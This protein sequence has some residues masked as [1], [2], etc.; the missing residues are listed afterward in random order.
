MLRHVF[1][2][3]LTK[4][5]KL[6]STYVF[7]A[8]LFGAAFLW[9]NVAGGAF[10]GANAGFGEKVYVNSPRSL[11]LTLSFLSLMSITI[12][13]SVFARAI[14]QDFELDMHGLVCATPVSSRAY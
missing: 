4:R 8:V 1:L 12:V 9:T 10:E 14:A 11:L 13:S 2:F 6:V 3:E 7:F 5:K